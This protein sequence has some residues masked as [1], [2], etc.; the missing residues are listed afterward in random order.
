MLI[1]SE[2]LSEIEERSAGN[3]KINDIATTPNSSEKLLSSI[4]WSARSNKGRLENV[5][6]GIQEKKLNIS[7]NGGWWARLKYFV[8][9]SSYAKGC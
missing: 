6:W 5:L 8:L 3:F 9:N 4:H 1:G 2:V 7:Q